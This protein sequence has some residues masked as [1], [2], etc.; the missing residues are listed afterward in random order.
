MLL[1]PLRKLYTEQHYNDP[2]LIVIDG[3][4]E[5]ESVNEKSISSMLAS[6]NNN[7]QIPKKLRFFITTRRENKVLQN[8]QISFDL[9]QD[10]FKKVRGLL[11]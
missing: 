6:F 8:F 11:T 4:D 1:E 9:I 3:L 5:E 7:P 10:T 2:I